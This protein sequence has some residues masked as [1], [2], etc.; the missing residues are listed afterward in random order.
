MP[1]LLYSSRS[2]IELHKPCKGNCRKSWGYG[3]LNPVC[4]SCS[5]PFVQVPP[6]P[7]PQDGGRHEEAR[8]RLDQVRARAQRGRQ[9]QRRRPRRG[10][11]PQ[12]RR[13]E[14]GANMRLIPSALLYFTSLRLHFTQY[15]YRATPAWNQF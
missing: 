6:P 10:G 1:L 7:A 8:Q 11:R 4:L 2:C 3:K 12:A 14:K 13:K 15:L 9:R 5:L